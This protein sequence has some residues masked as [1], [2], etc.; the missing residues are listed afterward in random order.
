MS[1]QHFL[2]TLFFTLLSAGSTLAAL[3]AQQVTPGPNQVVI[4]Y[5]RVAADYDGWGLHVWGP[6]TVEGVTW[7]APLLPAGQD[8]YGI[9]WIITM[10][11]DADHLNYIVHNGDTKD[12]GPDQ[13][14]DFTTLGREI[15]LIQ[16]SAE[17]FSAPEAAKAALLIAGVG[18]ITNKAQAH[19]LTRDLIAWRLDFGDKAIYKLHYDPAG[20]I[21]VT[22]TGLEGGETI[23]LEFIQKGLTP[24]LLEKWPH[25]QFALLLKIPDDALDKVP[26]ILK[27]QTAVSVSA[28]DGGI[29]TATALQTPGVLDD[30]YPYDGPLGVTFEGGVPTLRLWAPTATRL[31]LLL[32]PD[33]NPGT[34]PQEIPMHEDP[35]TGVWAVTGEAAW[36]RQY[37]LYEVTVYVR[38]EERLVTT[39]VTDPYSF[40][41]SANS[42]RSQ[43]VDLA[44]AGLFPEGWGRGVLPPL[45]APEDIVLYELH[46]RDFSAH[47][48]TVP[49]AYR[50]RFMAFTVGESDG[51]K[52]LRALAGAGLTHVHLLPA[53]DIATIQENAAERAEIDFAALQNLPP[54]SPAQQ[55]AENAIRDLDGFNW[56]YDPYHYTVP[57][58][59]YA[60]GP[61]GPARI[62][63]FRAMVEALHAAGL[64][65]VMDVVYNHTN[66]AGQAEKSVLDKIV[67][68]YY[69]RL[70]ANGNVATSSCCPNT[71][72]EHAMME[73][74]MLDSALTWVTAYHVD[75]FRFDLMGHHMLANMQKL[76]AALDAL[77]LEKDRVDGKSI[78]IY[79]EGWN[80][81]EVADNARGVNASQLNLGGTGIGSFNDRV[82]DALRGGNPFG[83]LQE[84]GFVTGLG[85]DPN[86]V[87][88]LPEKSQ[89]ATLR[90]FS[91]QI[92]VSLAGNLADYEIVDGEGNAVKG[93]QVGYNGAPAGYARDPQENI[94]YVSA[95]DNETLFDAIAY[96]APFSTSM[97][98]RVRMQNLAVDLVMLGQ[99]VPFFDGGIELLRSKS[100][101]RDSYNSGDWFNWID[102]TFDDNG[103][104]RGLPIADKNQGNWPLMADLLARP[105]L[106]P[107]QADILAALAHFEEML[108]IRKSSPLFRLQTGQQI[109]DRLRF[110]N[111]GPEMIPGLI[112]M[113]IA[114]EPGED[115][116]PNYG[117]LIVL[118]NANDE[119]QTFPMP[120]ALGGTPAR[121]PIQAASADPVVRT[122]SYDAA[123]KSFTVPGRTTA[124]FVIAPAEGGAVP[125][126][127]VPAGVEA[128][129][130][131]PTPVAEEQAPA[132]RPIPWGWIALGG[133]GVAVGLYVF[134][135][136]RR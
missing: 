15:W 74:L 109:I 75:G 18:D 43:I 126:T 51:M 2:L 66:A 9:Y 94:N 123:A 53:F 88:T 68:G 20:G 133:A 12:P 35:Q 26:G 10:A 82:R 31:R 107:S 64:R 41:L 114:D 115:L 42:Q 60:T 36:N 85:Y 55:A 49:E 63:E 47:D 69:Y 28:P 117:G 29:L 120:G 17:Q 39:L 38:Q 128:T 77:T 99:G 95:H 132:A 83:G 11:A 80:F 134:S 136:R 93:S 19:W 127:S 92:M 61:D 103:W 121:H 89:L 37:Y 23:Q 56:G 7:G 97:A 25:L 108:Q 34:A 81:G 48:E 73:K 87:S 33:A 104:G 62:T 100:M 96:K 4:H 76:R 13:T 58:G 27:G 3:P 135:R 24:A 130:I 78:Y 122:A 90:D 67:P 59:S 54:D 106:Q 72:T 57:E 111:T 46:I 91:T 119:A 71:A 129:L 21:Y 101:D 105:E 113:S 22:N 16:G 14:L 65:L 124:V 116:D 1:V 6:T 125:E 86:E 45:A 70:D 40:S 131:L 52:H 50:G 84:Q 5:R 44:E 112:V 30:L 8:D 110:H 98:E 32:F 118:F 79:G 102:F